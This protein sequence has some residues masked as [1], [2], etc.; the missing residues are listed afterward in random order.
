M[1]D[2]SHPT[3]HSHPHLPPHHHHPPPAIPG[4]PHID[5]A[6]VQAQIQA[7]ITVFDFERLYDDANIQKMI[8]FLTVS[9]G[10]D[11]VE[12]WAKDWAVRMRAVDNEPL[13]PAD[14]LLDECYQTLLCLIF[15][16]LDRWQA[17]SI[18]ANQLI[19]RFKGHRFTNILSLAV[20]LDQA[21]C[22]YTKQYDND[23]NDTGDGSNHNNTLTRRCRYGMHWVAQSHVARSES[24]GEI[25]AGVGGRPTINE[26]YLWLMDLDG[27]LAGLG[28]ADNTELQRLL[29]PY[30]NHLLE[31]EDDDDD[32]IDDEEVSMQED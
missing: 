6:V 23:N 10:N 26:R 3:T 5:F 18:T 1:A 21:Q 29:E 20:P 16:L 11:D 9:R 4:L 15:T 31:E 2:P 28:V 30:R 19:E 14:V 22:L 17:G 25:L 7:A 12:L 24:W 8:R 32:E 13:S 27:D